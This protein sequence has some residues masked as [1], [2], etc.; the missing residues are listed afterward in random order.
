M[1]KI[2]IALCLFASPLYAKPPEG[3]SP[4]FKDFFMNLKHPIDGFGCC[5]EADCRSVVTRTA[6]DKLEAFIDK[7]SFGPTAPNEWVEVPEISIIK[8]PPQGLARPQSAI[9]CWYNYSI[10]CYTDPAWAG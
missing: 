2:I 10:M 5:S 7:E 9:V 1:K 4:V 8:N 6:N 3:A